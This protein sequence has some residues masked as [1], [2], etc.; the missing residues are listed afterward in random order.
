MNFD[1]VLKK[2][3]LSAEKRIGESKEFAELKKLSDS[4]VKNREM[5][6]ISLNE[7]KRYSEYLTEKKILDAENEAN[8]NHRDKKSDKKDADIVLKEAL[9]IAVDF[10]ENL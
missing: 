10:A 7:E 9:N 8:S 3:Q 6:E 1:E 2:L 5:T 4:F